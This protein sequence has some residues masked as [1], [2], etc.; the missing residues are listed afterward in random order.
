MAEG[1]GMPETQAA[2]NFI[3]G[4]VKRLDAVSDIRPSYPYWHQRQ[5]ASLN[6]APRSVPPSGGIS[7]R[8]G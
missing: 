5:F 8:A 1:L 3:G 7:Y 2:G 6:T 4:Q